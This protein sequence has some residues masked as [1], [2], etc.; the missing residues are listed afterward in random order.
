VILR[1][2]LEQALIGGD[3][4]LADLP[5][6]WNDGMKSLLGIVPPNDAQIP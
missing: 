1:F 6:A 5:A 4:G 2:R 3:L